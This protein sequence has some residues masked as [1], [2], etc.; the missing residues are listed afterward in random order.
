MRTIQGLGAISALL[1][2]MGAVA[3]DVG[4]PATGAPPTVRANEASVEGLLRR[5]ENLIGL[6]IPGKHM[7]PGIDAGP[8][9]LLG[10]FEF[11]GSAVPT[12]KVH[13]KQLAP[14]VF[15]VSSVAYMVGYW[16]FRVRDAA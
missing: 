2:G 15:E 9:L 12:S 6:T 1:V 8:E 16:R 14:G 10:D 13:L 7:A 5:N 4:S 3:Q 11:E